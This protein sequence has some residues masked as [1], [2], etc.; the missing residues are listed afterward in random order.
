MEPPQHAIP[1]SGRNDDSRHGAPSHLIIYTRARGA[2]AICP[3]HGE[4]AKAVRLSLSG[5]R[6]QIRGAVHPDAR[7][8]QQHQCHNLRRALCRCHADDSTLLQAH[9]GDSAGGRV[10]CP[11]QGNA[12]AIGRLLQ[13]GIPNIPQPAG[14]ACRTMEA[15]HPASA[16][17]AKRQRKTSTGKTCISVYFVSLQCE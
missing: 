10:L 13:P 11:R 5:H 9:G 7:L 12:D 16:T 4:P 14:Q 15:H 8:H 6:T 2:Q 1:H 17:I 3:P